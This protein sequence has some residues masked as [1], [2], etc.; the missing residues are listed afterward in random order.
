MHT[1]VRRALFLVA[2]A[3]AFV[4]LS[5]C[6]SDKPV[7]FTYGV[8]SGD[9]RPDAA[10]VWTRADRTSTLTAEVATDQ[11]FANVAAKQEAEATDNGDFTAKAEITGLEPGTQYYYRFRHGDDMS[12]TGSFRTAPAEETSAAVRFVFS[13]DTDGTVGKDGSRTFDFKVLDAA[14]AEDAEFFL[15]FG[16][17]IYADSPYGPKAE[18]LD[19]YRAK[20]KEN[21][22]IDR[23]REILASTSIYTVWD[24]HEVENDFAGT[25]VDPNLLAAG[26]QAFREYM[27]LSGDASPDVLYRRYRWGSAVDVIMLDERS[28][29]DLSVEEACTPAG[30]DGPDLLPGLGSEKTPAP[31]RSF[32]TFIGLPEQTDQACL[33]ALNDPARTMLGAEQKQFLLD[34]LQNSDATFK[35]IVNPVPISELIALPYDRWEG[36]RAERD[37]ILRFIGDNDIKNVVFLTTDFHANII[38][39]VRLNLATQPVAVE[40]VAGPIAHNTLGQDIAEQQGK[41]AIPAFEA[42]LQQVPRA[43]CVHLDAFAYGLVEVDPTAG[44]TTITL[45]DEDGN[46][47]CQKVIRA[48]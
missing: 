46:K 23:L 25:I 21:R 32:R 26:R 1:P 47:L 30:A 10:V 41:D 28:F 7:A 48:S 13:G 12:K 36:Y 6:K 43:E 16:D 9:V 3:V 15:Y 34:A 33:D 42:L 2:V 18:T 11:A 24:D 37:E 38:S 20:Y 40:A 22:A 8:A 4:T 27:P 14:R 29:R 19:A 39:D 35:F 17:A 5:A 45:K 44:T 31:F